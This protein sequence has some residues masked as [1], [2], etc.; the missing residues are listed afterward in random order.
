MPLYLKVLH[1]QEVPANSVAFVDWAYKNLGL[2]SATGKP[3]V[4]VFWSSNSV[5]LDGGQILIVNSDGSFEV[6]RNTFW[7]LN[8]IIPFIGAVHMLRNT[9][10]YVLC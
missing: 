10:L 6:K 3:N 5:C 8:S 9:N 4:T 7:V 1:A 2:F